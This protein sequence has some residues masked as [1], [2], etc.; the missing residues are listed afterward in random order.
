M[1]R[2]FAL[3]WLLLAVFVVGCGLL[4]KDEAAPE[5][6]AVP[7]PV[8]PPQAGPPGA[9]LPPM[10]P[11]P[12]AAAPVPGTFA[13]TEAPSFNLVPLTP[14]TGMVNNQPFI[15]AGA[16]IEPGFDP[17]SFRLTMFEKPLDSPTGLIAD[18]Q[19]LSIDLPSP[20]TMGS[21]W[22]H[23][24]EY[25]KGHWEVNSPGAPAQRTSW[26]AENAWV[27]EI[28]KW[29]V[30]EYNTAAGG[31]Q[32]VGTASVK[33]AVC[34]KGSASFANSFVAGTLDNVVVRYMMPPSKAP[35]AKSG[36]GGA[37]ANTGSGKSGSGSAK[38]GGAA[39]P[40]GTIPG[41]NISPEEARRLA[42][43]AKKKAKEEADKRGIKIAP[44]R[45]QPLKPATD[46]KK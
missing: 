39:I 18:Q 30:A 10:A 27:M 46:A 3:S 12:L 36:G 43:E 7:P 33:L 45:I 40:G 35:S 29:D 22:I 28:T 15:V 21:S 2:L 20:P 17:G 5:S 13:W 23:P 6:A 41:G 1:K 31:A 42:E 16:V 44:I 4:G 11:T 37:K 32:A 25:G 34:Y 24:M 19:Y 38:G 9:A 14:A 26:N 8:A